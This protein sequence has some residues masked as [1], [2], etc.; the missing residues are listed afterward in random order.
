MR[1]R[2][3]KKNHTRTTKTRSKQH[4]ARVC[5]RRTHVGTAVVEDVR[6]RREV[7]GREE[8]VLAAGRVR[9]IFDRLDLEHGLALL[10]PRP[11]SRPARAAARAHQARLQRK[12]QKGGFSGEFAH[13][14]FCARSLQ[15]LQNCATP[16]PQEEREPPQKPT[17][18]QACASMKVDSA[19]IVA[20]TTAGEALGAMETLDSADR[21][22]DADESV[23]LDAETFPAPFCSEFCSAVAAFNFR[24]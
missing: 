12:A 11:G 14:S 21:D 5:A 16:L 6:A 19:A 4:A 23:E 15:G 8:P 10:L 24:C 9:G 3:K 22:G 17:E 7:D 2:A 18:K 1:L 13:A 20:S